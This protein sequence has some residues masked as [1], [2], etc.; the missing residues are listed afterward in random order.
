MN[1]E[2]RQV[3]MLCKLLEIMFLN[4]EEDSKIWEEGR[5]G[6]TANRVLKILAKKRKRSGL[7]VDNFLFE[8]IWK[9]DHVPPKV[10]FFLLTI[11]RGRVLTT[12]NLKKWAGILSVG[13]PSIK[14]LKNR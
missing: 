3:A 5:H 2:I 9:K 6:F 7:G 14:L 13:M 4:E 12:E 11:I 8:R 10:I 1:E